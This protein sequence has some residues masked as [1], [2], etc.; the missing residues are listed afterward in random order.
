MDEY[1]ILKDTINV[2]EG[3][4][5]NLRSDLSIIEASDQCP[6][7]NTAITDDCKDKLFNKII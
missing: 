3:V 7:C 1:S 6:L 2:N 5:L 4:L